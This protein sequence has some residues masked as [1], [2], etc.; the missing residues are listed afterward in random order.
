MV[1]EDFFTD[2]LIQVIFEKAVSLIPNIWWEKLKD[3]RRQILKKLKVTWII[4]PDII[5]A[6]NEAKP[7]WV[8]RSFPNGIVYLN[9]D[10]FKQNFDS[11]TQCLQMK[12]YLIETATHELCHIAYPDYTEKKVLTTTFQWL[13]LADKKDDI[14]EFSEAE[15]ECAL[16]FAHKHFKV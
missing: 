3:E 16:Y 6:F 13:Y 10:F 5:S 1:L 9:Q 2:E 7:N 12:S 11:K 8:A 14:Q 4:D 15:I